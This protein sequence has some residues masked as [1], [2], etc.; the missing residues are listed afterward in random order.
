MKIKYIGHSSFLIKGNTKT[1]HSLTIVTDPYDPKSTG[2]PYPKQE[3]DIVTSSHEGHGDHDY[4]DGIKPSGENET[5]FI[6]NTP[7]EY[8]IKGLRIYGLKSFHDDVEGTKRGQNTI[9]IFDFEEARIAHLGDL[10]HNLD[11][12][13]LEALEAVDILMI[14]IGGIYTIDIK[15]ALQ[16][17]ENVEPKAVIPMHFKTPKHSDTFKELSTLDEFIKE[18]GL[19]VRE[20]NELKIKSKDELGHNI[21]II[22][23]T[24]I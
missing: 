10:G 11:S 19:N 1:N 18:S 12:D 4:Y 2:F 17:I 9:Y 23:F 3:T 16:V 22:K 6:I 8:E 14:P 15:I 20:M 13:Q 21:D 7:G 24:N 5:P